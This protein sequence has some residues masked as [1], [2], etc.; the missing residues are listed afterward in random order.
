M[1][2]YAYLLLQILHAG[3]NPVYCTGTYRYL[4]LVKLTLNAFVIIQI[5]LFKIISSEK[6]H[7]NSKKICQRKEHHLQNNLDHKVLRAYQNS[8]PTSRPSSK[9]PL[10]HTLTCL[11][12]SLPTP[13]HQIRF[14]CSVGLFSEG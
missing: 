2:G 13:Y 8:N 1:K 6:L 14:G 5:F 3:F 12:S 9:I 11:R 10:Q 4:C 7:R